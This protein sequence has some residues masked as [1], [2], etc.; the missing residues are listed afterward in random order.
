MYL[1]GSID[2]WDLGTRAQALWDDPAFDPRFARLVDASAITQMTLAPTMVKAIAEDVRNNDAPKVAL[3]ARSDT[4]RDVFAEYRTAL[5]GVPAQ[6]F[7]ELRDGARWL[8]IHLPSIW[9]PEIARYARPN[10]DAG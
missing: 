1:Y 10:D 4:I 7:R 9:P 2:D 3:I 5:I 8:G 6:I